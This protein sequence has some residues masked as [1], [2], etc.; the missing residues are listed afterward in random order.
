VTYCY[1][2]LDSLYNLVHITCIRFCVYNNSNYNNRVVIF[3]YHNYLLFFQNDGVTLHITLDKENMNLH[4]FNVTSGIQNQFLH[5]V[6]DLNPV[7]EGR[8]FPITF[9]IG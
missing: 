4:Q 2:K 7:T 3:Q 5:I 6:M 1:E 8:L 9:L